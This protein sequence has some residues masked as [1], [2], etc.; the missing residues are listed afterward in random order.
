VPLDGA[1]RREGSTSLPKSSFL[2][3]RARAGLHR[4]GAGPLFAAKGTKCPRRRNF[5]S[6]LSSSCAYPAK[7]LVNRAPG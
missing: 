3:Q 4:T 1:L 7:P 5:A 6:A 2:S